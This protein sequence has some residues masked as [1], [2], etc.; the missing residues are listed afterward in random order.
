MYFLLSGEGVTDMGVCKAIS[1]ICEGD[2][3]FAGPMALIVESIVMKM[4]DYSI[5]GGVCGY[6]SEKSLMKRT[7]VEKAKRPWRFRGKKRAVETLYF[8]ENARV[9]A[10][11]AKEKATELDD[12]VV[13]ILFRDS[14]GTA[15]AGRGLWDDKWQS[16][17][18]GFDEEE[19]ARGVPMI[20]KPKS[21]AWLICAFKKAAYKNC[22]ALEDRS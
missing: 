2:D 3:Y 14:D 21:E 1:P 15:S 4:Q 16:M 19:F 8:S 22:P 20:P 6:V 13:A 9:L 10:K 17:I 18:D 11:I 12:E 7:K 5:L